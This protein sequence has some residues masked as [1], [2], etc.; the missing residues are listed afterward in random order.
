LTPAAGFST[1]KSSVPGTLLA[2]ARSHHLISCIFSIAATTLRFRPVT[3]GGERDLYNGKRRGDLQE[4][5]E[6]L[7]WLGLANTHLLTQGKTQGN[8]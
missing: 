3:P 5:M 8:Y 4:S 1:P 2:N 6:L 7:R